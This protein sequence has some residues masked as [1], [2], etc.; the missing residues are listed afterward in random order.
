MINKFYNFIYERHLIWHKRHILKQP[1]PWT[2]DKVL[3]KYKFCCI[4]RELDKCSLHLI[5]HVINNEN[6][7]P[8]N[9]IFNILIYRRFNTPDFF[10]VYG[11][12]DVDN[13][14]FDGLVSKM[15]AAK[16]SGKNLFNDAY[17]IC[18]RSF[19]STKRKSDKHYQQLLMLKSLSE[20]FYDFHFHVLAEGGNF[21]EE[22]HKVLVEEIPLTGGFLAY[23]YC[24]D[25]SWMPEHQGKFDDLNEFC[26][27]G[28]GAKRGIDLIF[29]GKNNYVER[30]Q[31]LFREQ[32][33][34]MPKE[35]E[36]IYYKQA[37]NQ[38]KWL[39]LSNIQNSL[40][41]FRKYHNLTQDESKCRKRKYKG[42]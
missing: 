31:Q 38:S 33:K 34:F 29:P 40:C 21:I 4:Y 15:D 41:E 37:Y 25:I 5:K 17:I 12:Q 30:C 42:A 32:E 2:E 7:S 3:Q 8:D 18:Q 11:T 27:V 6:L 10:E 20:R 26:D 35:W 9:K 36:E 24:T 14:D 23:Q 39:S 16:K 13:F 1:F 28:P 19:E 22:L